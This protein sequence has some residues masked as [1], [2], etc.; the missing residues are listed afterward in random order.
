MEIFSSK[1]VSTVMQYPDGSAQA[2]AAHIT[3]L[4]DSSHGFNRGMNPMNQ[5]R[6]N[7]YYSYFAT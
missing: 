2:A 4:R 3:N 6:C 5:S 1:V 7:K